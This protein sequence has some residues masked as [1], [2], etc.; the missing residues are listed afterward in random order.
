[1][2]P[3]GEPTGRRPSTARSIEESTRQR[4]QDLNARRVYVVENGLD[5]PDT[6]L[7]LNPSSLKTS[8][9]TGDSPAQTKDQNQ[10]HTLKNL[11][12]K[13]VNKSVVDVRIFLIYLLFSILKS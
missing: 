9:E 8:S 1:M 13:Q 12:Y 4:L 6:D 5:P 10:P 3:V 7:P 11:I 2:F